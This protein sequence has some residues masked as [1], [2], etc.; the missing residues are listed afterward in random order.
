MPHFRNASLTATLLTAL[1]LPAAAAEIKVS[2]VPPETAVV[3]EPYEF[4]PTVANAILPDLQFA[5]INRPSWSES[6]RRSGAIMGTPSEPGVFSDIQ[7]EAWDGVHFGISAPFTITVVAPGS[8]SSGS[9]TLRW[10]RPTE[11]ID[12]SALTNLAGY[13]IRYGT[14]AA[15]LNARVRV[16]S[17]DST[18]AEIENLSPGK[19]YFEVAGI[20]DA[21]L[22]GRFSAIVEDTLP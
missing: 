20:T 6:Y 3:G 18:T 4:V 1:S 15:A 21:N 2:G 5:Y 10:V 11:N 17:A 22:Q 14:S 12:G 13:L 16:E 9:V 8:R 7:I 19:W